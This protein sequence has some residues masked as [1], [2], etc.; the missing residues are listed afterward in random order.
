MRARAGGAGK[1]PVPDRERWL[2]ALELPPDA[3][4]TRDAVERSASRIIDA[5]SESRFAGLGDEFRAMAA[6]RRE[7]AAEA[8]RGL[9]AS[10]PPERPA[11]PAAEAAPPAG[12]AAGSPDIRRNP[13]L[14]AI[15]GQ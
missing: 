12:H 2:A 14:D 1:A 15:F 13:D 7:G 6:R 9:L 5:Y 3:N 10:L 8:R 4:V 11:A